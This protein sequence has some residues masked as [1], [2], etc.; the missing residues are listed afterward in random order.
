[1]NSLSTF[2]KG[3]ETCLG[4]FYPKRY[5]IATFPSFES[6][7][8]AERALRTT[9][10]LPDDVQAVSGGEMLHFFSELGVRT[11]LLGGLMTAF[12]RFIGTE[13]SFLDRDV[14]EARHGAGFL[15]V[16]CSTEREADRIRWLLTPLHPSAMEW[17]RTGAVCSMV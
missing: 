14:W 13:A 4:V 11:G 10:F 2:F 5:I 7:R 8:L 15:A 12:S 3:S 6:A 1:M 17:Y 16:H 9:G